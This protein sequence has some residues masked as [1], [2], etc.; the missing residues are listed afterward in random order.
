MF[1]SFAGRDGLLHCYSFLQ[2]QFTSGERK[3]KVKQH[4]NA[5]KGSRPFKP[6]ATSTMER[7]KELVQTSTPKVAVNRLL[8]EKGGMENICSFGD[9]ACDRQQAANFRRNVR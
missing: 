7:L 3:I 8:E 9:I 6:S 2:Y 5:S 4:G 1:I